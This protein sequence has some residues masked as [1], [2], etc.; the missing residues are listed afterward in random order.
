MTQEA[1]ALPD[2]SRAE[3]DEA[4]GSELALAQA[5]YRDWVTGHRLAAAFLTGFIATH[6]ATIIGFWLPSIGLPELNWP[7]VNGALYLPGAGAGATFWTGAAFHYADGFMFTIMYVI[8]LHPAMPWRSTALGNLAK[9]LL[10]G[11]V[12]AVISLIWM[13][14]RVYKFPHAGFFSANLGW[15]VILA[16]FIWHWVYGF[17]VGVLYNPWER[18]RR[19]R[20]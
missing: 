12:L 4:E 7:S 9:G 14:P 18:G 10:F 20:R 17:H 1:A 3:R 16:V 2:A 13:I 5:R 8:L 11:S 15:K 19:R 6:M